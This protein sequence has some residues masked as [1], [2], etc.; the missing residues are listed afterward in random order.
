M[1][2]GVHHGIDA[3][4]YLFDQIVT[5]VVVRLMRHVRCSEVADERMLDPA[6]CVPVL[7]T[8]GVLDELR[9]LRRT[10]QGYLS[11][12]NRYVW[13]SLVGHSDTMIPCRVRALIPAPLRADRW[14]TPACCV[15]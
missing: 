2:Y 15:P 13:S 10:A 12:F 4:V 1:E 6:Y 3:L 5:H 14:Q 7:H 8:Y 9:R 11:Q